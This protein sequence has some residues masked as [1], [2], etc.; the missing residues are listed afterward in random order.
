LL[1][2]CKTERGG[3]GVSLVVIGT[4]PHKRSATIEVMAGD[5]AVVGAAGMAPMAL[6]MRRCWRR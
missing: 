5:E 3:L 1:E 6:G 4:D 2:D